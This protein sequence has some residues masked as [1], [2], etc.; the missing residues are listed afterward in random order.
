MFSMNSLCLGLRALRA[1]LD[2]LRVPCL[3]VPPDQG[4]A[5][6]FAERNLFRLPA[7]ASRGALVDHFVP[8]EIL[9]EVTYADREKM[10]G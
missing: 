5:Q 10:A 6:E 4:F 8:D 1:L 9:P 3:P 7:E 2:E